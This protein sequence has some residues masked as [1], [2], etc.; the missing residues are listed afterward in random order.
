[1]SVNGNVWVVF[2][3]RNDGHRSGYI[4]YFKSRF[5]AR[6]AKSIFD[7]F[8]KNTIFSTLDGNE[9]YFFPIA[10]INLLF[11]FKVVAFSIRP[12]DKRGW[13]TYIIWKLSLT[14]LAKSGKLYMI[15][16]VVKGNHKKS[17]RSIISYFDYYPDPELSGLGQVEVDKRL[18][19]NKDFDLT[20]IGE[21]KENKNVE[22]FCNI[23]KSAKLKSGSV[24]RIANPILETKLINAKSTIINKRVELSVLYDHIRRTKV[25]FCLYIKD[26]SSGIVFK[27][28]QQ[29]TPVL[30]WEDSFISTF[31]FKGAIKVPRNLFYSEIIP[32]AEEYIKNIPSSEIVR[33]FEIKSQNQR[34]L[35]IEIDLRIKG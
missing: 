4:E 12:H 9:K 29:G 21:I 33:D 6:G 11:G 26:Q 8:F 16:P 3:S 2:D 32:F 19:V 23:T 5:N 35:S 31:D 17:C 30:I 20:I 1:M 24:G 18:G 14:V 22:L 10:I 34:L 15:T 25:V 27:S 28:L 7:A 13:F